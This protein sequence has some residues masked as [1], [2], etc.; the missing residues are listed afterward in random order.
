MVKKYGDLYRELRT[1]L[2]PAEKENASFTAR[3]LLCRFSEKTQERLLADYGL[4]ASEQLETELLKAAA[5]ILDG[6]PLAYV[7]SEWDFGDLTLSVTPD[8]LIPR[9]DTMA[10]A[11]LALEAAAE[12]SGGIRILDVCTGTGCIGLWLATRLPEAKVMLADVSPKALAVAN[13]NI[14]KLSLGRRVSSLCMDVFQKPQKFLESEFELLVANPPYVTEKE[15]EELPDSV[16]RYEP[17]LALRGGTDGLDFYRAIPN[18]L[19]SVLKPGGRICFE[20]GK[21]QENPVSELLERSGFSVEKY[22]KDN[23]D[24][25]RAVLARK[26]EDA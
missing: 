1:M 22:K 11:E 24:I 4:Y 17:D 9:D 16:K 25:T 19:Y 23:Q 15:M 10:V 18:N 21:G 3:Q 13:G 26:R 5:R 8:T 20:F 14:R 12:Y 6:E 7:I 2:L